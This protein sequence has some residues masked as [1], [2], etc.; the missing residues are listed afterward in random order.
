MRNNGYRCFLAGTM[1][2]AVGGMLGQ[3]MMGGSGK[4]AAKKA[5]AKAASMAGRMSREAGEMLGAMGESLAHKL[6]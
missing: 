2:G 1:L 3:S 6:R 5:R 4:K